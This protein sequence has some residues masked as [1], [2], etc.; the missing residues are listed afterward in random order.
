MKNTHI[1][2]V[3]KL[4]T[5]SNSKLEKSATRGWISFGMH[6][7]PHTLSGRN[8]CPHASPGCAAACLNT[9]GHGVFAMVQNARVARTQWFFSDREGF[10]AQLI[11][12]IRAGIKY[13]AKKRMR[14]CFRL[15]LTSDLSWETLKAADGRT[16]LDH[17]PD[18][19]FYD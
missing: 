8:T 17:F 14:P 15:N 13:A 16:V 18:V 4:L 5:R 7:S 9:A 2:L 11:D 6:L 3:K 12:E 1:K 10:M 19:Q